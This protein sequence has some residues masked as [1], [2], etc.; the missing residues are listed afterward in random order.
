MLRLVLFLIAAVALAWAVIW[1]SD[2]PGQVSLNWGG[3]QVETSVGALVGGVV[4]FT[5]LV[6]LGYRFWLFLTRAPGQITGAYR[7]RR[8]RKG[9]MALTTG[10][11]AVAAGDGEESRRQVQKADGLLG[12]PPLTLLLKAQSAQLNGDEL[13]AERFFTAM[14]TEPEMEFLGLRGLLNQAVK[15]GDDAK[16]LELARRAQALKPKSEWLAQTLFDLEARAGTWV[17]AG[18]ALKHVGKLTSAS[19]G[20]YR[21]RE[22][23]VA[24]GESLD[25]EKKG[26]P[27]K[28]LKLVEKAVSLDTS[29]TAAA[30]RLGELYLS[31]GNSSKAQG[32]VEKAWALMPQPDLAALY[33]RACKADSGLK[34]VTA[35]QKLLLLK[36]GAPEGHIVLAEAALEAQLW[37]QARTHLGAAMEAGYQTRKVYTL[38][39]E[40]EDQDRGDKDQVRHWLAHAATATD[41]A[42]WVCG[43]CGHVDVNW[44]PHC[45]KCRAFDKM[46]WTT[47]QGISDISAAY[48]SMRLLSAD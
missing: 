35:A 33:F 42:A 43:D 23:V 44:S 5:V 46:S 16:A 21:H 17:A 38:M 25:A 12:E 22:A 48:K 11:V 34:K 37:G 6:A 26:D 31:R 45:P 30:L 27:V 10:M 29:L 20:Q 1:V 2:N 7:E 4:L 36:P 13:A 9:Y 8:S 41:D 15:R 39:A 14:L 32:V 47:P 40:L 24:L 3:W 28:A 18:G 19:K